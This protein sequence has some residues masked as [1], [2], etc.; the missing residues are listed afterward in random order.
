MTVQTVP[1]KV[2]RAVPLSVIARLYWEAELT[3]RGRTTSGE[4]R[5][6]IA[7]LRSQAIEGHPSITPRCRRT[8][9]ALGLGGLPPW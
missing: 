9:D 2:G 3:I 8:L 4:R 1:I 7:F 6:S 5:A